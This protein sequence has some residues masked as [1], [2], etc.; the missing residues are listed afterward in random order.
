L[1][2]MIK[3]YSVRYDEVIMKTI[4]THLRID[5]A[6]EM[7]RNRVLQVIETNNSFVEGLQA[8]VIDPLPSNEETMEQTSHI[9]EDAND[10]AEQ[11]LDQARKEA[12]KLKNDAFTTA[13]KK[14][15]DDG[16]LQGKLELQKRKAEYDE[17]ERQLKK[18]YEEMASTLEPQMVEI[19]ASLVEKITG[20][21]V[22]KKEEV[23]LYLVEKALK[24]MDKSDEYTI[25]VSKED[26]DYV[27]TRKN[28]LLSAIGREVPLYIIEDTTLMKNKCLIETELRV[29]DCSLDVQ[30]NNL[31]L[32]LKLISG[33]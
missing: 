30:L 6:I 22:D 17:K 29:I 8:L 11:I 4:D 20:I 19:I 26:Y 9:L 33:I 7:K 3:A 14:G 32:D 2:N 10:K 18:E 12:E 27:S 5:Q 13:Q 28:L 23:I 24:K 1:S 15:Y 31:I 16:I 25:R 21:V